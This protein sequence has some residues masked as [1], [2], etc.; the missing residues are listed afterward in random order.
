M[1]IAALIMLP[2]IFEKHKICSNRTKSFLIVY[3]NNIT[4]KNNED[5]AM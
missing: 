1:I 2:S 4:G 5:F 3:Q